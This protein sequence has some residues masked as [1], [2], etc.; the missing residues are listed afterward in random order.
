MSKDICSN[1]QLVIRIKAGTDVSE[2]MLQLWQQNR[3]LI[4]KLAG[5]Y[6]GYA[7]EEDLKQEGYFGLCEAVEHFEPDRGASFST[8]LF[9]YV[10]LYMVRYC[11]NNGCIRIPVH[12]GEWI[13]KYQ[14]VVTA[15][16]QQAGRTP[17]DREL[18]YHLQ[19]SK[20]RLQQ[21]KRAAELEKV[22][23]L[24][25]PVGEDEDTTLGEIVAGNMDVE[26]SVVHK[27]QQEQLKAALWPLVD[28]LPEKQAAVI[29]ARYQE[30]LT[31]QEAGSRI[32][33]TLECARQHQLNGLRE[34]RKPSRSRQLRPFLYDDAIYGRAIK[35]V[36][37][38]Y[39]NSTWTSSTERAALSLV[40]PRKEYDT[41]PV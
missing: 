17:T 37:V 3:A 26:T 31:L 12:L 34:L 24:D 6:R 27:E 7:D 2:N 30:G 1:E 39:F 8:V 19:V 14:K 5:K 35:G 9:Q 41:E 21:I 38:G 29:R 10:R 28:A 13:R 11:Q 23:S 25:I 40:E 36:G 32:G 18:Y 4:G 20:D 15:Y 16:R 33:V 22:W